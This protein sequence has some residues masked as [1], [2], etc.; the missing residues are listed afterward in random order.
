MADCSCTALADESG[1]FAA[2]PKML[3]SVP[4]QN[5][6]A[7]FFR[8]RGIPFRTPGTSSKAS[9][10][11]YEKQIRNTIMKKQ[12]PILKT[13]IH[14]ALLLIAT[15]VASTARAADNMDFKDINGDGRVDMAAI[16]SP[17]T[18]TV[19]LANL[20]GSYTVCAIL[21]VP[22]NRTITYVQLG[23]FNRDGF[24]DV[25]ASSSGGGWVYTFTWSGNGDGT[26]GSATANK[27]SL[28]KFKHGGFF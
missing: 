20:D 1:R 24:M 17:T 11:D 5:F 15:A 2:A 4:P 25:Y 23:D 9:P 6:F 16:T 26:F 12:I 8:K 18:V 28:P 13:L 21:S 14:A 10:T 3:R 7:T 19:S 27:W 22:K